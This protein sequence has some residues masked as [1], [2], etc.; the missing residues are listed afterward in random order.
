M[1]YLTKEELTTHIYEG[2]MNEI[3]R[4][5]DA[6]IQSAI[7]AAIEEAGGYL[8]PR[9]D[10]VAVFI[11]EGSNRNPV[12]LYFVKDIAKWHFISLSNPNID[13]ALAQVRY[14]RAVKWLREVQAGITNPGLPVPS[15]ASDGT[16]PKTGVQWTSNLKRNNQF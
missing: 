12:L 15:L 14:D 10:T 2:V 6:V 4:D 9:Y 13:L 8:K 3:S 5:D 1:P 7:D 16:N 11:A